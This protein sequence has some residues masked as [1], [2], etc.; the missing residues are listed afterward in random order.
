MSSETRPSVTRNFD[1]GHY[2]DDAERQQEKHDKKRKRNF[3]IGGAAT[4]LAAATAAGVLALGGNKEPVEKTEPRQEPGNS[5][6]ATPGVETPAPAETVP[7]A[8]EA[9]PANWT[10]ET[11]PLYADLD[12]DGTHE[13]YTGVEGL[14]KAFELKV[15]DYPTADEAAAAVVERVNMLVNWGADAEVRKKYQ[16][17]NINSKD[18]EWRGAAAIREDYVVPA[19]DKALFGDP[20]N[21]GT[22]PNDQR[23]S[24]TE[25]QVG[26]ARQT[27]AR[28]AQSENNPNPYRM[29]YK[30]NKDKKGIEHIGGDEANGYFHYW[31]DVTASDNTSEADL[32]PELGAEP[33]KGDTTWSVALQRKSDTDTWEIVGI[34]T[35]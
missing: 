9:D 23:E 2:E 24:W 29:Q 22:I 35:K 15:S 12:G 25:R 30:I 33:V 32:P 31:I 14:I 5:A 4:F 21:I 34:G 1:P 3:L 8:P 26:F 18:N 13:A 7:A 6:P 27:L 16:D 17:A 19:F 10:P 11:I 28:F 20:E